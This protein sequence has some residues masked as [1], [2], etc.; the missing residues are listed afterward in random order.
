MDAKIMNAKIAPAR[1]NQHQ[2]MASLR[3]RQQDLGKRLMDDAA[4]WREM[5]PQ[6]LSHGDVGAA[7]RARTRAQAYTR[8]AE[9]IMALQRGTGAGQD[10]HSRH[11]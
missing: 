11:Q 3:A 10:E 4:L 1:T 2:D 6:F 7:Q 8:C 9:L 5:E